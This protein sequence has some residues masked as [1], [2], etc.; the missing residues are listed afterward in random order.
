MRELTID[1]LTAHGYKVLPAYNG[2]DA[3]DVSHRYRQEIDLLLTDVV[4]PEMSGPDLAGKL[5]APR[6]HLNV[7]YMSGY[8]GGLLAHHG[9]LKMETAFLSKPFTK[10]DL[11]GQVGVSLKKNR[12]LSE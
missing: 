11:L 1:L 10:R 8:A 9:I 2:A 3:L 6:P 4:M 7:L 5:K 12:H